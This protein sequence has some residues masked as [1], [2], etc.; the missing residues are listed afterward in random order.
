MQA[1]NLQLQ[2]D[3]KELTVAVTSLASQNKKLEYV[4]MK[5]HNI[6]AFGHLS[7]VTCLFNYFIRSFLLAYLRRIS[8]KRVR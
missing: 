1:E 7:L 2:K 5:F 4:L 6:L 3:K 8:F